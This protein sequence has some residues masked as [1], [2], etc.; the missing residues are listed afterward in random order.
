M[1]YL[2]WRDSIGEMKKKIY[3]GKTRVEG[4]MEKKLRRWTVLLKT[5]QKVPK[6][7]QQRRTDLSVTVDQAI[8]YKCFWSYQR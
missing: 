5:S 2:A 3:G 7:S 4:Q 6:K 8:L 1:F